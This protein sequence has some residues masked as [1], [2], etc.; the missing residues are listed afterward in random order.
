MELMS[1][2]IT[3]TPC[4]AIKSQALADF[5]T[6]WTEAHAEPAPVDLE[7][8]NMYFNDSLML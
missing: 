1:Y 2:I 3:Y 5:I 8:W 7:Y 6:K 4:T